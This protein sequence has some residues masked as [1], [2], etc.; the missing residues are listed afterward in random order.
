[1][2]THLPLRWVIN[3][4]PNPLNNES[5]Y[6][7]NELFGGWGRSRTYDVSYVTDL[8]SAVF[9]NWTYSPIFWQIIHTY[10]SNWWNIKDL[11][12]GPTGYEPVA[13]TNWANVPLRIPKPLKN[14]TTY[15]KRSLSVSTG[16]IIY[17]NRLT[18]T[19]IPSARR[20]LKSSSEFLWV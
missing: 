13:L 6:C 18:T 3:S 4:P 19:P 10:Q 12:L 14:N 11:N 7:E 1:M 9:A 2:E 20:F 8:Q 16:S 5:Q 17:R 15:P